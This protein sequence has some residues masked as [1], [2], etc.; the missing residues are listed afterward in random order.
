MGPQIQS[1]VKP[2]MLK[3]GDGRGVPGIKQRT[4]PLLGSGSVKVLP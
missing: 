2:I 1:V 4:R 3:E